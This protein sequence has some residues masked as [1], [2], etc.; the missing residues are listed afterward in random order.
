MTHYAV[1]PQCY[2]LCG[3]TDHESVSVDWDAVDCHVCKELRSGYR[4]KTSRRKIV[5]VTEDQIR[6]WLVGL[7][8]LPADSKLECFTQMQEFSTSKVVFRFRHDSFDPV[9][10]GNLI[11]E[12]PYKEAR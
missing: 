5:K 12:I 3:M 1:G 10:P 4:R 9:T 11:P 6:E 2:A 7:F 8:G